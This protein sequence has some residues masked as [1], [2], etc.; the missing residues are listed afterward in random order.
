MTL[1]NIAN[2]AEIASGIMVV[3][4]V[5]FLV[6]QIRDNTKALRNAAVD[7]FYNTYLEVAADVNRVPELAVATRKAFVGEVMEPLENQHFCTYIQ[8]SCSIVERSLIMVKDG[9]LDR[10]TFEMGIAPAKMIIATP[11]GRYWYYFLKDKRQL[12]RSELY[13]FMDNFYRE[14]DAEAALE[15]RPEASV[16]QAIVPPIN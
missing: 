4:T 16:T 2:L 15:T 8:R 10:Q 5:I 11:A 14:L 6:I 9:V 3:V 13:E 1:D 7:N 12:F